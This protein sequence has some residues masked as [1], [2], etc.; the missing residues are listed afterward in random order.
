MAKIVSLTDAGALRAR[1]YAIAIRRASS[2][3]GA[4]G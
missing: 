4:A 2:A 1:R 3:R